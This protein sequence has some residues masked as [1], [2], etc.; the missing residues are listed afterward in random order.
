VTQTLFTAS[1]LAEAAPRIWDK[2]RDVAARNMGNLSLL[3]R[4]AL[5]EIGSLLLELRMGMLPDQ[6]LEQLIHSLADVVRA[7]GNISVDVRLEGAGDLPSEVTIALY[8]VTQEALNNVIKHAEATSVI[9][10]ALIEPK[11]VAL[12]ICD[13]GRGFDPQRTSAEHMGLSIMAERVKAIGGDLQ[14]QSEVGN[15]TEVV[16]TWKQPRGENHD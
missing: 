11:G 2:D 6:S 9:V 4:S 5:A 1:V 16:V 8:R 13:D 15:G 7:R 14:L 12:H 10:T 3:L